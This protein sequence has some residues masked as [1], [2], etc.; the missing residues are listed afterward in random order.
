MIKI[1]FN[2]SPEKFEIYLKSVKSFRKNINIFCNDM[3]TQID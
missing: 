2:S 1:K 3:K